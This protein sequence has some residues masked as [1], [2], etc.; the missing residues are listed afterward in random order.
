MPGFKR[1]GRKEPYTAIGIKRLP[2]F[3]CGKPAT[4]QWQICSDGNLNRPMCDDCDIELNELVLRFM[5]DPD[6][7]KKIKEYKE[8]FMVSPKKK[9]IG[10]PVQTK[11]SVIPEK[12]VLIKDI[13]IPAGTVFERCDNETRTYVEG[14]YAHVLGLSDNT[15]GEIVYQASDEDVKELFVKLIE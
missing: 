2:C 5:R 6:A 10:K 13:V 12:M 8:L 9:N 4:Q 3:R 15:S 11:H 14:N 1:H 7:N